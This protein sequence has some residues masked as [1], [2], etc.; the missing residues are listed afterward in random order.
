MTSHVLV[1][2]IIVC[3]LANN[4]EVNPLPFPIVSLA[5]IVVY[6]SSLD[7]R[8]LIWELRRTRIIVDVCAHGLNGMLCSKSVGW[9]EGTG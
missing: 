4:G 2:R 3:K 6:N 9:K 8:V 7:S 1:F 5:Y